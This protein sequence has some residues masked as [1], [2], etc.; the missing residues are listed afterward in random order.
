[1]YNRL[2]I[3]KHSERDVRMSSLLKSKKYWLFYFL[4]QLPLAV[5]TLVGIDVW[6]SCRLKEPSPLYIVPQSG[7]YELYNFDEGT[8]CGKII[9]TEPGNTDACF[10]CSVSGK[11]MIVFDVVKE[12]DVFLNSFVCE[13][14]DFK[15]TEINNEKIWYGNFND[16]YIVIAQ[17]TTNKIHYLPTNI[18]IRQSNSYIF[19]VVSYDIFRYVLSGSS[20]LDL[21]HDFF[22]RRYESRYTGLF[23]QEK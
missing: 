12:K 16:F 14:I 23:K 19:S 3:K 21:Y 15:Q 8:S 11:E 2:I 5:F 20:M 22:T 1:M 10:R 4:V 13:D 17:I 18:N 7:T 9:I 6:K